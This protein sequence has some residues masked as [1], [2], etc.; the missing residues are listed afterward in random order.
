MTLLT[1]L[2]SYRVV[3][4]ISI[5][6]YPCYRKL[7]HPVN[8]EIRVIQRVTLIIFSGSF[9]NTLELSLTV[10]YDYVIDKTVSMVLNGLNAFNAFLIP[11]GDHKSVNICVSHHSHTIDKMLLL[12]VGKNIL[13]CCFSMVYEICHF[14]VFFLE[15]IIWC[16]GARPLY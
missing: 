6:H 3:S 11:E 15:K 9:S 2:Q 13:C 7:L 4:H 12:Y 14:L 16:V 5:Y 1:I 8:C 10:L